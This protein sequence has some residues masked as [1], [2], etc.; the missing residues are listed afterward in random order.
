MDVLLRL[1]GE[2]GREK[3]LE[4]KPEWPNAKVK[5]LTIWRRLKDWWRTLAVSLGSL[6]RSGGR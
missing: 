6:R 4:F 3:P 1:A 2:R 5:A